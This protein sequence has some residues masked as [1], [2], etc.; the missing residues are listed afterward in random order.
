MSLREENIIKLINREKVLEEANMLMMEDKVKLSLSKNFWKGELLIKGNVD[1][2][3]CSAS[4]SGEQI[5]TY[6]WQ[7]GKH[8]VTKGVC[9]HLAATLLK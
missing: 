5:T 7:C 1:G 2:H 9:A 8:L 6:T 4:T 3:S